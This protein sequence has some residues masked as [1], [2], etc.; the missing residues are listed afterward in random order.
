MFVVAGDTRFAALLAEIELDGADRLQ[1]L[2]RRESG[3]MAAGG[4]Q[5]FLEGSDPVTGP[6]QLRGLT[7][8][9]VFLR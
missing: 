7:P 8:D 3:G 6:A 2:P 1:G 4:A 9:T 5:T